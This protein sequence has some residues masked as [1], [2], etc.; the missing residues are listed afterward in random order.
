MRVLT[1]FLK[2]EDAT[3]AVEY[4]VMLA[5]IMITCLVAIRALG[6]SSS[7]MWGG[8]KAKLDAVGF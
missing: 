7:G 5:L 8:N 4:A 1:R 6:D 3:T 2:S